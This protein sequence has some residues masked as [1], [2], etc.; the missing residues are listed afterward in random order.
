MISLTC[1]KSVVLNEEKLIYDRYW[2]TKINI[3]LNK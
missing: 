1:L 2:I 3:K